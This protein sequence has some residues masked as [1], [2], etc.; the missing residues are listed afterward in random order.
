VAADTGLSRR[1]FLSIFG[2]ASVFSVRFART[3]VAAA[4]EAPTGDRL[5]VVRGWVLREDDLNHIGPR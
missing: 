3:A 5:V 2:L 4:A 1:L